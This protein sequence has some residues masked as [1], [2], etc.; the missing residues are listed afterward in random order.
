MAKGLPKALP[1]PTFLPDARGIALVVLS[2]DARSTV[3]ISVT[4]EP[5]GG[6]K[7][8]TTKPLMSAA[9]GAP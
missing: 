8:P 4:L 6:S 2:A 5:E 3:A 9:F 7:E 1:S